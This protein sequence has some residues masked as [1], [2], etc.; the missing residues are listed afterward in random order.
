MHIADWVAIFTLRQC[1]KFTLSSAEVPIRMGTSS[2]FAA[3]IC[4]TETTWHKEQRRTHSGLSCAGSVL[5]CAGD[6]VCWV[7]KEAPGSE[8][9]RDSFGV[10][11]KGTYT[12]TFGVGVSLTEAR[13]QHKQQ[14]GCL[15]CRAGWL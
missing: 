10:G 15:L 2:L 7:Q 9:W 12:T 4:R 13:T 6:G 14:A 5:P 8:H 1:L 3:S 11:D